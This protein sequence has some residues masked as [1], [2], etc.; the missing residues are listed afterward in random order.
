[1]MRLL[2]VV[3]GVIVMGLVMS[4][5]GGRSASVN[6]PAM[7]SGASHS[8]NVVP[9]YVEG[10]VMPESDI[11]KLSPTLQRLFRDPGWEG[12]ATAQPAPEVAPVPEIPTVEEVQSWY[13]RGGGNATF[14]R[15]RSVMP[16]KGVS[17]VEVDSGGYPDAGEYDLAVYDPSGPDPP[18][19]GSDVNDDG[20]DDR[21]ESLDLATG[22]APIS[23]VWRGE[24]IA[25]PFNRG[26]TEG[27]REC[28]A[29][30]QSF[31]DSTGLGRAEY[32]YPGQDTGADGY[33][34]VTPYR[35]HGAIYDLWQSTAEEVQ[36]VEYPED[37][38]W[39]DV[40][41][42]AVTNEDDN[43]GA[44]YTSDFG[45]THDTLNTTAAV[46]WFSKD[47]TDYE[48]MQFA[49]LE[50]PLNNPNEPPNF[51]HPG[52]GLKF[53]NPE[54]ADS[55]VVKLMGSDNAKIDKLVNDPDEGRTEDWYPPN[56]EPPA[57]NYAG[58]FPVFGV[59]AQRW[60][61]DTL[62]FNDYPWEGPLGF[63]V[64][65]PQVMNGGNRIVGARGDYHEFRQMFE[66]G[67][68]YWHKYVP[69]LNVP[70]AVYIFRV[71]EDED[72]VFDCNADDL[73]PDAQTIYYGTGGPLGVIAWVWPTLTVV[74]HPIYFKAFPYGGP[75]AASPANWEDGK[76]YEGFTDD[77]Y[78]WR[79]RDGFIGMGRRVVRQAGTP[80]PYD[81]E[82]KYV[83]RV[84]LVL[85]I[86]DVPGPDGGDPANVA[87]GD[88]VE[89]EVGHLG[90]G[91]GGPSN[92]VLLVSNSDQADAE[93]QAW[94]DVLDDDD[95][96]Y[97]EMDAADITA[98]TDMSAYKLVIWCT[99]KQNPCGFNLFFTTTPVSSGHQGNIVDY[100]NDGGNMI[101]AMP[102]WWQGGTPTFRKAF[103]WLGANAWTN[104][105][106]FYMADNMVITGYPIA[107]G[108]GGHFDMA[109]STP[110]GNNTQG[111]IYSPWDD[112]PPPPSWDLMHWDINSTMKT[113]RAHDNNGAGADG[114]IGLGHGRNWCNMASTLPP[115]SGSTGTSDLVLNILNWIDPELPGSGGGGGGGGGINSYA[116][117][118]QVG[119]DTLDPER[120]GVNAWVVKPGAGD[121]ALMITGGDGSDADNEGPP[122]E[123]WHNTAVVSVVIDAVPIHFEAMAHANA[124]VNIKYEW[125]FYPD[126][127]YQPGGPLEGY[128]EWEEWTRYTTHYYEGGVDPDGAG[129]LDFGD[130][131]PVWVRAYDGT[132]ASFADAQAAGEDFWD[133]KSVRIRV[134]GPLPVDIEDDGTVFED[135][136]TP[137]PATGDVEV[138]LSFTI[139]GGAPDPY[140]DECWIDWDYDYATFDQMVEVLI[141][142]VMAIA[143]TR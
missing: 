138:D 115:D 4:C 27:A 131:F 80:Q 45:G 132:Y 103:G 18:P 7:V 120:T 141:G 119:D 3:A 71:P 100:L 33:G 15:H 12:P 113:T 38:R 118:L 79:F 1:M 109:F 78:L 46:Q 123:P 35:L 56:T 22:D 52:G 114:G 60:A 94:R 96:G 63:P 66:R 26:W 111:Y 92:I 76:N 84:M 51:P 74:G 54:A 143:T 34:A 110:D 142:G 25:N 29:V 127:Y 77:Y 31:R 37:F 81:Y 69:G 97:D 57:R 88:T 108:P 20:I 82:A 83:A 99:K 14:E 95:T 53:E 50:Y 8:A 43:G 64:S 98:G 55:L 21:F 58:V 44:Y 137:D 65:P 126:W 117:P 89:F 39:Y 85:Q 73:I 13:A 106:P 72:S 28:S 48:E 140:Y 121:A 90:E 61:D 49:P 129:P 86:D 134:F 10:M 136:Y 59:I 62:T 32:N 102:T 75:S 30:Y 41:I 87:F 70:D 68:I 24:T 9:D 116:G 23:Y 130:P 42:A 91:G 47:L 135:S 139:N 107:D 122:D 36:E 124:D 133:M 101:I 6:L 105:C 125:K 128:P 16:G 67:I 2:M 40:M 5:G 93:M 112:P 17:Y 104:N 19:W 11:G